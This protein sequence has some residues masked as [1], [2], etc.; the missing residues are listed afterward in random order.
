M[1]ELD[2]LAEVLSAKHRELSKSPSDGGNPTTEHRGTLEA[3]RLI[4]EAIYTVR[5]EPRS[6]H[7][8]L[9]SL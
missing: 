1:N 5:D 2:K 6:E 3:I 9:K 7:I 4:V 8:P